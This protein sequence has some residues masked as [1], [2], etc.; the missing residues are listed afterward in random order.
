MALKI[1]WVLLAIGTLGV[2]VGMG[3]DLFHGT[4]S[5]SEYVRGSVT[6]VFS[7][8]TLIYLQRRKNRLKLK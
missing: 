2:V 5:H 3:M 1:A 6:M 4:G 8:G 7:I